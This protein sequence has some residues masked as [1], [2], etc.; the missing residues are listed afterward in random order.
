MQGVSDSFWRIKSFSLID[1]FV[2]RKM[3][4]RYHD[5]E[6]DDYQ[7]IVLEPENE[8]DEEREKSQSGKIDLQFN[9]ELKLKTLYSL[10]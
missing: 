2:Q 4:C 1:I 10:S 7:T 9:S 5:D 6:E 3:G 8:E